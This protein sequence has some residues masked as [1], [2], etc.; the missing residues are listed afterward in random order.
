MGSVIIFGGG[1]HAKV[2]CDVIERNGEDRIVG[3]VSNDGKS[4]W[5]IPWLGNDDEIDEL[6][7]IYPTCRAFV[8]IGDNWL[9]HQLVEKLVAAGWILCNVISKDATISCRAVIPDGQNIVIM[10]GAVI[11]CDAVIGRG[12]IVNTNASVDHETVIGEF[13]HIA[14]GCALSGKAGVGDLTMVGIGARVKDYVKV[15]SRVTIGG[16]GDGG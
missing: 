13:S 10:P 4:F 8:A 14:P 1:G 7:Q 11:N 15:G 16:G 6:K 3:I 9:R 2:I 5:E 12:S